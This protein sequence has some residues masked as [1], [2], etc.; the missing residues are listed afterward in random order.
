VNLR[1]DAFLE[2]GLHHVTVQTYVGAPP[3]V[4]IFR[5]PATPVQAHGARVTPFRHAYA[6]GVHC[7]HDGNALRAFN[8]RGRSEAQVAVGQQRSL[9]GGRRIDE[10][11]GDLQ[12]RT[13]R[14][15]IRIMREMLWLGGELRELRGFFAQNLCDCDPGAE[16]RRRGPA[17]A[18]WLR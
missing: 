7:R 16:P 14:R 4:R 2:Y 10:R 9:G 18:R 1:L 12:E 17:V 3:V 15:D 8:F 6:R 13:A 5:A 11:V